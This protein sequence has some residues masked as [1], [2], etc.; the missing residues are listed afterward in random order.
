MS[1]DDSSPTDSPDPAALEV[2]L[3]ETRREHEEEV[4]TLDEIDD[5]ALRS[6]RTAVI[7][8]GFVISAAGIAGPGAVNV[9]PLPNLIVM[10]LGVVFLVASATAGI[11][12]ASVSEYPSG[13]GR[14]FVRDGVEANPSVAAARRKVIVQYRRMTDEV[15]EEVETN[16]EL[17]DAV[18]LS[19]GVGVLLLAT[20]AIAMVLEELYDVNPVMALIVAGVT[21]L[22]GT[23]TTIRLS[24]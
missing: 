20:N 24:V 13:V 15:A 9:T 8:V 4:A 6:S 12:T 23:T 14:R 7:V 21:L 17:L 10:G 3:A 2:L 1:P 5:K 16:T 19:L 18:Q 22:A 11:A